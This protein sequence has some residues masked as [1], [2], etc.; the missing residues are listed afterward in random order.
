MSSKKRKIWQKIG[1]DEMDTSWLM[2][3]FDIGK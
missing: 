3:L 1:V 2:I